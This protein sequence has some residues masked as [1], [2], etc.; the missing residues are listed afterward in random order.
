MQVTSAI[1]SCLFLFGRV[2]VL[3]LLLSQVACFYQDEETHAD[4]LYPFIVETVSDAVQSGKLK[5]EVLDLAKKRQHVLVVKKIKRNGATQGA[6]YICRK[7]VG[8]VEILAS[9]KD[10]SAIGTPSIWFKKRVMPPDEFSRMIAVR[11]EARD[12]DYNVSKSN[13]CGETI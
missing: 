1:T 8:G 7:V 13:D 4:I 5:Q 10:S 9:G 11:S 3:C 2:S 6:W 12:D